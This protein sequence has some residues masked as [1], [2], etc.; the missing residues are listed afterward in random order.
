MKLYYLPGA[1]STVPHVALEWIDEPYEAVAVDHAKIKSAEYLALNPQG[2]VPLLEDGDFVLSQNVAILTYLDSLYP[3]KK[4]FGSKTV[5][6]KAKAMQWLAFFNADL[7]KA[8]V[9]LFRLPAYAEGNEQLTNAVR[10]AAAENILRLLTI[11]N[12]HLAHHIYFG[13]QISVADVYL[14]V[15]LRWCKALGLNYSHLTNLEPFYQRIGADVGVKTVLVK[16]G[17]PS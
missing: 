6:D 12:E 5:Q 13:E 3:D 9:Q 4:L 2:T 17:L 1:C 7:H 8:F 11:A 14:Y 15:E 16:Q 10:T